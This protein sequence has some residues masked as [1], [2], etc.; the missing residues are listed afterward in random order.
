MHVHVHVYEHVHACMQIF[1]QHNLA[2][3]NFFWYH[4]LLEQ[5]ILHHTVTQ[6]H[7]ATI[8]MSCTWYVHNYCASY[9]I[10][11][12]STCIVYMRCRDAVGSDR[13]GG[14][15]AALQHPCA[16]ADTSYKE[17]KHSH[18]T[19]IPCTHHTLPPHPGQAYNKCTCSIQVGG[20]LGILAGLT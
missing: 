3:P 19:I 20:N 5:L 15:R 17:V 10:H 11:V 8:Y 12:H 7:S 13:G 18:D 2:S 1:H 9:T 14:C 6:C 16:P 4:K